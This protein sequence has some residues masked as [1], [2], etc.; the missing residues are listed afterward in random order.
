MSFQHEPQ[1]AE[2]RDTNRYRTPARRGFPVAYTIGII[3]ALAGFVIS[4]S[5]T[6]TASVNGTV[7][8]CT[9]Q[10]LAP[11]AAAVVIVIALIAGIITWVRQKPDQRAN[12]VVMIVTPVA[13]A[14]VAVI[15]V[16]RGLGVVGGP[17]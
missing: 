4:L 2:P 11:L 8:S 16:L 12:L 3:A 6:S 1:A 13:L 10:D 15:H 17:C 14:A 5:N 9:H 7:T